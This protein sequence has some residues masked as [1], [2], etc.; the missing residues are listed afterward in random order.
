MQI[1]KMLCNLRNLHAQPVAIG[2]SEGAL[3]KRI[4]RKY[5][6]SIFLRWD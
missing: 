2:F 3:L 1:Y 6:A 4:W 5:L